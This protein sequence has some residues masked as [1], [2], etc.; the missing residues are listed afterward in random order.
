MS[1]TWPFL[2]CE[3]AKGYAYYFCFSS[4][5]VSIASISIIMRNNTRG[6]VFWFVQSETALNSAGDMPNS[7][8]LSSRIS[9][10]AWTF[11]SPHSS[12]T[13]IPR[14]A[15]VCLLSLTPPLREVNTSSGLVISTAFKRDEF[16]RLVVHCTHKNGLL[17]E[18]P[19][20][21]T[22]EILSLVSI[23]TDEV[24][25]DAILCEYPPVRITILTS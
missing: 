4:L 10:Y 20:E 2:T 23:N 5:N 13:S 16:N 21:D 7:C 14:D 25:T 17:F 11:P 24:D 19:A 15:I 3:P 9:T 1:S 6:H 12:A 8:I 22:G 18:L